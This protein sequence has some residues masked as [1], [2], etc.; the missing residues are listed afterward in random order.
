MKTI[1]TADELVGV[2]REVY[3]LCRYNQKACNDNTEICIAFWDIKQ[4]EIN[5]LTKMPLGIFG[6]IRKYP[7][8]SLTKYRRNLVEWGLI[9]PSEESRS[10]SLQKESENHKSPAIFEFENRASIMTK[11]LEDDLLKYS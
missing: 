9:T 7:P 3:E 6:A 11:K 5:E 4:D 2:Q 1:P 8:E 10:H